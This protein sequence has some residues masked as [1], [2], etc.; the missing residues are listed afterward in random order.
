MYYRKCPTEY[1]FSEL[2]IFGFLNKDSNWFSG[3]VV[4]IPSHEYVD[5]GANLSLAS[6]RTGHSG[7]HLLVLAKSMN[8][9]LGKLGEG[10]PYLLCVLE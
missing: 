9:Y 5:P 10:L 7:V 4:S 6:Q 2:C 1:H 3:A 8:R